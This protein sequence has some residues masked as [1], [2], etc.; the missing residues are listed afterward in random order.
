MPERTAR[1]NFQGTLPIKKCAISPYLVTIARRVATVATKYKNTKQGHI[2]ASD[3][4]V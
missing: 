1:V 4:L 2:L 3:T